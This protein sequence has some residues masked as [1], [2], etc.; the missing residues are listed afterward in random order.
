L[1]AE[2]LVV[3][4]AIALTVNHGHNLIASMRFPNSEMHTGSGCM[5]SSLLDEPKIK[6]K[7]VASTKTD[8]LRTP[9]VNV[10]RKDLQTN[11]K[12]NRSKW[13]NFNSDVLPVCNGFLFDKKKDVSLCMN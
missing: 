8:D 13:S 1:E 5:H 6:N 3:L 12:K 9:E 10:C 2:A 4:L 7:T 11:N